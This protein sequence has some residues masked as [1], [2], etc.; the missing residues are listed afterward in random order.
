MLDSCAALSVL[1]R[2]PLASEVAWPSPAIQLFMG[3]I[4]DEPEQ[5]ILT[6]LGE[7]ETYVA[8]ARNPKG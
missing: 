4:G 1:H 6:T 5:P 7:L 2:R 3:H 8:K